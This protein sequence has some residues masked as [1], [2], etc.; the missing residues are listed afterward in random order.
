MKHAT[1]IQMI[2]SR[3]YDSCPEKYELAIVEGMVSPL[4]R[5]ISE[6]VRIEKLIGV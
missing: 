3:Y 1:K 5:Y 6:L 4:H 2:T